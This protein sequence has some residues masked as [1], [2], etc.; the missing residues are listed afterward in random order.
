MA[1]LVGMECGDVTKYLLR[2]CTARASGLDGS[3]AVR[4]DRW[5]NRRRRLLVVGR[6]AMFHCQTPSDESCAAGTRDWYVG[7]VNTLRHCASGPRSDFIGSVQNRTELKQSGPKILDRTLPV[8]IL[9]AMG[10]GD[11]S[12]V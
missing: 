1:L 5:K 11:E 10:A 2:L 9:Q 8:P 4:P 7:N 12:T 6:N 3:V